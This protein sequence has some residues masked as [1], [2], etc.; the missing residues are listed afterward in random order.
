M[1]QVSFKVDDKVIATVQK[2]GREAG[3]ASILVHIEQETMKQLGDAIPTT[4]SLSADLEKLRSALTASQ[5]HACYAVVHGPT[6]NSITIVTYTGDGAKAKERMLYSTGSAHL[7]EVVANNTA[8]HTNVRVVQAAAIDDIQTALFQRKESAEGREA[9]MTESERQREEIAKMPVA[10]QPT[11]LPGVQVPLSNDA[12]KLLPSF[13]VALAKNGGFIIT[14]K[15]EDNQIVVDKHKA[16]PSTAGNNEQLAVAKSLL[17]DNEPR[18]VLTDYC[19]GPG[20][21]RVAVMVHVC[22]AACPPKVKMP[23]ASGRAFF[24][25]QLAANNVPVEH[26]TE[27]GSAGELPDAVE[28]QFV[29]VDYNEKK[30]AGPRTGKPPGARGPRMLI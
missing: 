16:A 26:R 11:I 15:I 5:L 28:Q 12:V 19:E 23:Y 9:L 6:G 3:I 18:Y 2:A 17:P 21:P 8:R 7:R 20:K 22:P 25:S 13:V 24:L 30:D 27:T 4:R 10:P 14:F 29:P 1:L